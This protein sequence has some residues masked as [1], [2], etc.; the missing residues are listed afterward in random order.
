[1]ETA[2]TTAPTETVTPIKPSEA[3][4]LGRLIAPRYVI[5]QFFAEGAACA[6]GAMARGWGY[7]GDSDHAGY[8]FVRERLPLDV[9][10]MSEIGCLFD[11]SVIRGEDGDSAVLAFLEERGL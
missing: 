7:D 6:L 3:L 4:R 9:R 10:P 2:T 5:G 1:M 8:Q 11:R